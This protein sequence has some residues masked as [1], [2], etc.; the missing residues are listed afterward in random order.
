M[1][2][3]KTLEIRRG[4]KSG[5]KSIEI[6]NVYDH[7]KPCLVIFMEME[8]FLFFWIDMFGYLRGY[9]GWFGVVLG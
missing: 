2:N 4:T 5:W 6:K 9:G 7:M 8:E 3:K 1:E